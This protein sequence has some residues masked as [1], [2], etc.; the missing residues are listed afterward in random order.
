MPVLL[1]SLPFKAVART[2]VDKP[3]EVMGSTA[4]INLLVLRRSINHA[5]IPVRLQVG[6]IVRG[7]VDIFSLL[8]NRCYFIDT[9]LA[10]LSVVSRI[11]HID[12][13]G[14]IDHSIANAGSLLRTDEC[15][16]AGHNRGRE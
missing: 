11:Q 10:E 12:V 15:S 14:P 6:V 3:W 7:Y 5:R 8:S 16:P 4:E 13:N 9:A 1:C 2:A